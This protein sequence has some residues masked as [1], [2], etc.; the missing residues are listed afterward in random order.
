MVGNDAPSTCFTLRDG[1]EVLPDVLERSLAH[2][3]KGVLASEKREVSNDPDGLRAHGDLWAWGLC[4]GS[5]QVRRKCIWTRVSAARIRRR[6][7]KAF[8]VCGK[9]SSAIARVECR[10][11]LGVRCFNLGCGFS[12]RVRSGCAGCE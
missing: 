2:D 11:R 9:E 3:A 12:V 1:C 4:A 10:D 7:G 5:C 6:E 8:R